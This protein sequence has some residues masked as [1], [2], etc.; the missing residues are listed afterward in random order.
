MCQ[1]KYII[2]S[3]LYKY[4]KVKDSTVGRGQKAEGRQQKTEGRQQKTGIGILM[5]IESALADRMLYFVNL[6]KY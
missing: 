4:Q 2:K 1:K 3:N 6:K 5:N